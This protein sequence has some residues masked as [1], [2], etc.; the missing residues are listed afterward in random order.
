MN[1]ERK[2]TTEPENPTNEPKEQLVYESSSLPTLRMITPALL[3][4]AYGLMSR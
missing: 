3:L 1:E 4:V 2:A